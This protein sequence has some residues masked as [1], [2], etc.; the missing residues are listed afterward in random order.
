MLGVYEILILL[1]SLM[2]CLMVL[3][4]VDD[5]LGTCMLSSGRRNMLL[6]LSM[7]SVVVFMQVNDIPC[8]FCC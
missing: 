5:R 7:L 1:S 6:Q 8:Q 2:L 4:S 3:R